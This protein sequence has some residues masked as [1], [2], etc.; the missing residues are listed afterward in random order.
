MAMVSNIRSGDIFAANEMN[1]TQTDPGDCHMYMAI[2]ASK[3]EICACRLLREKPTGA[4]V[5]PVSSG[6]YALLTDLFAIEHDAVAEYI[7]PIDPANFAM[8]AQGIK[9]QMRSKKRRAK[10]AQPRISIVAG[11]R[12]SPK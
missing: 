9:M 10:S 3:T 12:C 1:S 5:H 8:I 7:G 2:S 11:G 6:M 4:R